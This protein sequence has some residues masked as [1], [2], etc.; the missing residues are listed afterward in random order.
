MQHIS[1]SD[2]YVSVGTQLVHVKQFSLNIDDGVKTVSTQGI[3]HGHVRGATSASG[4]ITVDTENF[5]LIIEEAR[6]AG[7]FQE[8]ETFDIVGLGKT[9]DQDYRVKAFGC[10]LKLSKVLDA[11][12]DGGDKLEH[13]LPYDVTSPDFVEIDGVP[14]LDRQ[15][16]KNLGL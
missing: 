10:K 6:R 16:L 5:K 4:E 9:I 2:V 7:S 13:T 15:H 14:Y 11:S 1:G 3:V 12:G 8:M